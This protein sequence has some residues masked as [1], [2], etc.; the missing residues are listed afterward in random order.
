MKEQIRSERTLEE[1]S[2]CE[3][4]AV[5]MIN[6]QKQPGLGIRLDV[7]T[8]AGHSKGIFRKTVTGQAVPSIPGSPF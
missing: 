3:D 8:E 7:S 5:H 6:D 1:E 4:R 2:F